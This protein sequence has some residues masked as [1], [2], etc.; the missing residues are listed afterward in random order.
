MEPEEIREGKTDIN[1]ES[2]WKERV[3]N[4]LEIVMA[5]KHFPLKELP[6]IFHITESAKD[7][8]PEADL[9]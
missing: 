6:K 5:K 1:K 4:A 2:G 9:S 8:I 3:G 7:K